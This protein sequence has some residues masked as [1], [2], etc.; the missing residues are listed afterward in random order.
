MSWLWH[1]TGRIA[2]EKSFEKDFEK[3]AGSIT[4]L[5]DETRAKVSG[6]VLKVEEAKEGE[7]LKEF[8]DRTGNILKTEFLAIINEIKPNERLK[9]G[10]FLKMGIRKQYIPGQ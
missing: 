10:Q 9:E 8:S 4:T 6:I 2:G 7:T 1:N 5:T 3:V